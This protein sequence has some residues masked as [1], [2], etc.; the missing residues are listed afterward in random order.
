MWCYL[1]QNVE[2]YQSIERILHRKQVRLYDE[3][4]FSNNGTMKFSDRFPT[5]FRLYR[6]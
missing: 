6:A 3:N 4:N 1:I 2:L 5:K